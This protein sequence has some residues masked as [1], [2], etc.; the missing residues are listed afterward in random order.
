[1]NKEGGEVQTQKYPARDLNFKIQ[2]PASMLRN[3]VSSLSYPVS[4]CH[5][6]VQVGDQSQRGRGRQSAATVSTGREA[7]HAAR[8]EHAAWRMLST[9]GRDGATIFS[10]QSQRQVQPTLLL[11]L[12]VRQRE[13]VL[14]L[15]ADIVQDLIGRRY[16]CLGVGGRAGRMLGQSAYIGT[17]SVGTGSV[18]GRAVGKSTLG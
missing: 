14:Q 9:A 16:T 17:D 12:V 18:G 15:L 13:A 4:D 2:I 7:H 1:M 3:E 8:E 6:E 5:R 10:A 11:D